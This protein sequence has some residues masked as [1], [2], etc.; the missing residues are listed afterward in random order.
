[1]RSNFLNDC[2]DVAKTCTCLKH[3][4]LMVLFCRD[5][6]IVP[7]INCRTSIYGG[8]AIFS[9]LGFIATQKGVDVREVADEGSIAVSLLPP[10]KE[11]AGK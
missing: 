8:F 1:M 4:Y 10:A 3:K 7:I 5:S 11:V 2:N 6:I 9:V